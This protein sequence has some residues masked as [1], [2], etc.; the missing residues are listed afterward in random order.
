MY[1]KGKTLVCMF[2]C[3]HRTKCAAAICVSYI[4]SKRSVVQYTAH[5]CYFGKKVIAWMS[6]H[7]WIHVTII[8]KL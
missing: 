4:A 3:V 8:S 5:D 7:C 1:T 6:I 2:V